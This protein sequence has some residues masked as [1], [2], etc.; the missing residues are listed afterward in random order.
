MRVPIQLVLGVPVHIHVGM[1]LHEIFIFNLSIHFGMLKT[2]SYIAKEFYELA[3]KN[4]GLILWRV[5][6]SDTIWND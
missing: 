3:T 6:S 5:P 2:L 4:L 1:S